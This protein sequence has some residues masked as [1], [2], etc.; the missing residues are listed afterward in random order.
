[1]AAK[2]RVKKLKKS[3]KV[4]AVKTLSHISFMK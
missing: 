3:K 2:K 4:P 1:M